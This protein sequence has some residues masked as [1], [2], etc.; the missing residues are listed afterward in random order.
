[1]RLTKTADACRM[2]IAGLQY[3]TRGLYAYFAQCD[4]FRAMG[5]PL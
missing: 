2:Y 4:M 5:V 3:G 1:M